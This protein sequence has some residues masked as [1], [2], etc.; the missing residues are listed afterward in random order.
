MATIIP[1]SHCSHYCRGGGGGGA[2][3]VRALEVQD[4]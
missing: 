3:K 2:T 1:C 4:L